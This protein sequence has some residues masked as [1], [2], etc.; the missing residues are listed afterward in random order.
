[1][2]DKTCKGCGRT[3]PLDAYGKNSQT[4]D[5]LQ[6]SCR[7]CIARRRRETA[8]NLTPEQQEAKQ[9]RA[10]KNSLA[11]RNRNL[12]KARAAYRAWATNPDNKTK[13]DRLRAKHRSLHREDAK[14]R[15][16]EWRQA[17][18]G[19]NAAMAKDWRARYPQKSREAAKQ[20]RQA[21]QEIIQAWLEANA[22]RMRA[23]ASRRRALKRD[24]GIYAISDRDLRR[25][26]GAKTCAVCGQAGGPIHIDHI[27]PLARGG[28]HSIGNLQPLCPG[29]NLSKGPKLMIEW[30][31]RG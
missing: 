26:Y 10:R 14:R 2:G 6:Y 27:I 29:C 19:R 1:M 18:P 12:D 23:K 24:A 21:N 15:T 28:R 25:L 3:L 31:A 22:E 16:R 4:K 8:A 11:W 17:N 7:E 13:V 30:R 20:Y 5:G 9:A